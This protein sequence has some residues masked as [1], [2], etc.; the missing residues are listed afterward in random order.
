MYSMYGLPILRLVTALVTLVSCLPAGCTRARAAAVIDPS[1]ASTSQAH[2]PACRPGSTNDTLCA[3]NPLPAN[4]Q[5]SVDGQTAYFTVQH[6]QLAALLMLVLL[7]LCS[8]RAAEQQ[9]VVSAC[10]CVIV[11]DIMACSL[12]ASHPHSD[13]TRYT[14]MLTNSS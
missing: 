5:P 14:L 12:H 13:S 11:N 6:C 1:L 7:M 8:C 3:A 4:T 9:Q 10:H 2:V